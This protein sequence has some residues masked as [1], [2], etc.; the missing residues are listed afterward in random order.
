MRAQ[1]TCIQI[2]AWPWKLKV[3]E[4]VKPLLKYL[5]LKKNPYKDFCMSV[6]T[7]ATHCAYKKH[8]VIQK[9]MCPHI[10]EKK[11]LIVQLS[12]MFSPVLCFQWLLLPLD[13]IRQRGAL[14]LEYPLVTLAKHSAI[15]LPQKTAT[16]VTDSVL[17]P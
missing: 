10:F 7:L 9:I 2:L 5:P 6:L 4:K 8:A 13:R 3:M 15:P 14:R 17:P 11:I 1:E 16:C 12:S